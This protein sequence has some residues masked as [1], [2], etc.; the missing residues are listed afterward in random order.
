MNC[1]GTDSRDAHSPS[2]D[3]DSSESSATENEDGTEDECSD[4]SGSADNSSSSE[5]GALNAGES[6]DDENK[7]RVDE[8]SKDATDATDLSSR[9]CTNLILE[10]NSG[11]HKD[12]LKEF[13]RQMGGKAHASDK[14][15]CKNAVQWLEATRERR[16][17]VLLSVPQ[18]KVSAML[19]CCCSMA[20]CP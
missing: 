16:P 13:V 7:K 12:L 2:V 3:R 11:Q 10:L 5:S 1:D 8:M 18:L 9:C 6:A 15:N 19:S 17:F 14:T 20:L 4:P